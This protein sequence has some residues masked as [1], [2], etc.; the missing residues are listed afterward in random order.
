M[1]TAVEFVRASQH[2]PGLA[3][4]ILGASRRRASPLVQA[5]TDAQLDE[6]RVLAHQLLNPG[7]N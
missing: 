1:I 2:R 3:G 7:P 6:L 4:A 5:L